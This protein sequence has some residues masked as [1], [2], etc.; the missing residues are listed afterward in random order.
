MN[1][2]QN[3][4]A[5]TLAPVTLAQAERFLSELANLQPEEAAVRRFRQRFAAIIPERMV[6]FAAVETLPY[7]DRQAALAGHG[8]VAPVPGEHPE[9]IARAAKRVARAEHALATHKYGQGA[10]KA[11]SLVGAAS[12]H[13]PSDEVTQPPLPDAITDL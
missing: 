7:S 12:I 2:S 13:E 1:S 5:G 4:A 3:D 11:S 6:S 9:R 10:L 8:D